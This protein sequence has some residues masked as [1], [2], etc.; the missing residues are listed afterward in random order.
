[1][2]IEETVTKEVSD[3]KGTDTNATDTKDPSK[4]RIQSCRRQ[5]TLK[6]PGQSLSSY[7]KGISI[8]E[9]LVPDTKLESYNNFVGLQIA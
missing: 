3:T 6:L 5:V 1:M 8:L 2:N 7:F 9:S 4:R